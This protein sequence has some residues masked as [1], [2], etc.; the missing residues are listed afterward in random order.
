MGIQGLSDHLKKISGSRLYKKIP[1]SY[2][3]GKRI[4]VDMNQ[5]IYA[6]C[7]SSAKKLVDSQ[8]KIDD[9]EAYHEISMSVI[10]RLLELMAENIDPICVFDGSSLE[11]KSGTLEKR[12]KSR[13]RVSERK[14]KAEETGDIETFKKLCIS[15]YHLPYSKIES[16]ARTLEEIGFNVFWLNDTNLQVKDGEAFCASLCYHGFCSAA[17][18]TDTDFHPFGGEI[19][20]IKVER[21]EALVDD[22]YV[23]TLTFVIRTTA[24][25][26]RC[27]ELDY[28]QFVEMCVLMGNDYNE[29][30]RN[31]GPVRCHNF[32]KQYKRIQDIPDIECLDCHIRSLEIFNLP[33]T[34]PDV[35]VCGFDK[36]CYDDTGRKII[37]ERYPELLGEF[38]I[39]I[40]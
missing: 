2:F 20:I 11:E 33:K 1:A 30:I 15:S 23:S 18:T 34:L 5:M 28:D 8:G 40:D 25:I 39:L 26:L 7:Y 36:Y 22:M 21:D 16:I 13:E 9:E 4:A 14:K 38:D 3:A 31:V 19:A 10:R 17:M 24:D 35:V 6:C 12:K 29:R 37:E 27:L 32:I